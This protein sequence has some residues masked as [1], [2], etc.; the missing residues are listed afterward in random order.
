MKITD[1]ISNPPNKLID[2]LANG[3]NIYIYIYMFIISAYKYVL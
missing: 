1:K 3:Y 2:F